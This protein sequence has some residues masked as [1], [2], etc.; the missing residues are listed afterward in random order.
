MCTSQAAS[1]RDCFAY[2]TVLGG[3]VGSVCR[4]RSVGGTQAERAWFGRVNNGDCDGYS[5]K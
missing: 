5:E 2:I 4:F 1:H 3:R